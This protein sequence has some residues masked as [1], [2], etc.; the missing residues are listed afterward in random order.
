MNHTKKTNKSTKARLIRKTKLVEATSDAPQS[1]LSIIQELVD[2]GLD[3]NSRKNLT[4]AILAVFL[5][6][7]G[8]A[9]IGGVVGMLENEKPSIRPNSVTGNL[10]TQPA[11]VNSS[12]PTIP[13]I[14]Q[15]QKPVN[16]TP[17]ATSTS[18]SSRPLAQTGGQTSL[19]AKEPMPFPNSPI[20]QN[21]LTQEAD[22]S[23]TQPAPAPSWPTQPKM[24][25]TPSATTSTTSATQPQTDW[26]EFN[27]G[28]YKVYQTPDGRVVLV[29]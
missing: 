2:L 6:V 23:L 18:L 7:L 13:T 4:P 21:D 5:F 15:T 26:K 10:K 1:K 27:N 28:K 14:T 22:L 8:G 11:Y 12:N 19:S 25:T 9:I 29:F 20:N 17:S 3:P 16:Q 24:Q